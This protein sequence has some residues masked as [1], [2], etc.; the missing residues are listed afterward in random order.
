VDLPAN[1]ARK[2]TTLRRQFGR[3]PDGVTL[4]PV[5]FET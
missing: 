5:D 4:V 1:T 2:T 3:V